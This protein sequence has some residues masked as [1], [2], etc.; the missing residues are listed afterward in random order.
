MTR[1]FGMHVI[2]KLSYIERHEIYLNAL[3]VSKCL[4]LGLCTETVKEY[5][6]AY[7]S[8]ISV[9]LICEVPLTSSPLT[10][11]HSAAR[12]QSQLLRKQITALEKQFNQSSRE[13]WL[14]YSSFSGESSLKS[15]TDN[16]VSN[17]IFLELCGCD[18]FSIAHEVWKQM[19]NKCLHY[20]SEQHF[21]NIYMEPTK[22]EAGF[23]DR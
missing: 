12:L 19:F 13:K 11:A 16:M 4:L 15:L 9:A 5:L 3:M 8:L 23:Y 1:T 10:R 7:S 21:I 20:S 17:S 6:H 22:S 18:G 14:F 2:K